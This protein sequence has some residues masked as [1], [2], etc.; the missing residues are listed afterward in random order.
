MPGIDDN[1]PGQKSNNQPENTNAATNNQKN[2]QVEVI[3]K[4]LTV[5]IFF[6]GTLNNMYNSDLRTKPDPSAADIALQKKLVKPKTSYAN[7]LSNVALLFKACSK[8]ENV[9]E[10]I[11][12]QGS[13]SSMYEKDST[14]GMAFSYGETGVYARVS[15]ALK[16]LKNAIVNAKKQGSI[17]VTVNVFGFSRGSFF[18]RYFCA[19]LAKTNKEIQINFVGLYDTV[20]SYGMIGHYD[21]VKPFDLNIGSKQVS[22]RIIHFTAQNDYRYHFP[23][24]HINTAIG[25]GIGFECSFPGAHSDIG[26]GYTANASEDVYLSTLKEHPQYYTDE[27]YWGWFQEQGYYRGNPQSKNIN[28]RGQFYLE[29]VTDSDAPMAF[30]F[31]DLVYGKR[32]V[33]YKDYQFILANGMKKIAEKEGLKFEGDGIDAFNDNIAEMQQHSILKILDQYICQYLLDHYTES[34]LHQI[35]LAQSGLSPEQQKQLYNYYIHNSLV[36]GDIIHG[37]GGLYNQTNPPRRAEINDNA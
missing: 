23:L 22:G 36:P 12:I 4:S 26:G 1:Q 18:A 27:I 37:A 3:I 5:N 13:G 7:D 8:S 9:I 29:T 14:P 11:Y 16:L 30:N 19:E 17:E 20:S 25:D 6:D 33:P 32:N 31:I 24:T 2:S 35:E 21:N 34:G 10:R 28:E 15:E